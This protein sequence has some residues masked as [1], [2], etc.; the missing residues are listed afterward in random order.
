[1][2]WQKDP[3]TVALFETHHATVA[4]PLALFDRVNAGEGR[5][6]QLAPLRQG[7]PIF[8]SVLPVGQMAG[9][10]P[11]ETNIPVPRMQETGNGISSDWLGSMGRP[12]YCV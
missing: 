12:L 3:I 7:P 1:M 9:L 6:G 10:G 8:L 11:W 2:F 5:T 4:P